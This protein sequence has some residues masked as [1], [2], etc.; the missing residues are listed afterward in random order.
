MPRTTP[1]P[2]LVTPAPLTRI[3]TVARRSVGDRASPLA[4]PRAKRRGSGG[5]AL[6]QRRRSAPPKSQTSFGP[7]DKP[8]RPFLAVAAL[9]GPP[10][11]RR[12]RAPIHADWRR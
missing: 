12:G 9:G 2:G 10:Y 1:V 11:R 4:R 6:R 5:A 3:S 7:Q 8:T